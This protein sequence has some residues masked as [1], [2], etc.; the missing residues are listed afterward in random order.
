V[1]DTGIIDFG[2]GQPEDRILPRELLR[3]AAQH[4]L[5]G[6]GNDYLQYGPEQ[7]ARSLRDALAG[8]LSRH[9]GHEVSPDE[10][11]VTNGASH[12]LD[13]VLSRY[14]RPGDVVVV[15]APTY[16]FGL[17]VLH[18]RYV[19]LVSVPVDEEG[20]DTGALRTVI[21]REKPAL[22][23]TIPVFHNPT[24]VSL[25]DA[26]RRQLVELAEAYRIPV[27]ADEVYQLTAEPDRL[28]PPLRRYDPRQV[29]SLGSFSKILGPG[30][31]LGWIECTTGHVAK[32]RDDGV[33][34]SGGGASPM[35][36]AI[37]E[38]AIRRGLQD[39]FLAT[40]RD[41]YDRRRRC[42]CEALR[43][44]LPEGVRVTYP[45][46]GY[47]VW[48]ELP[49][50]TDPR[51]VRVDALAA[52]VG[53]RPGHIFSIDGSFASCL[54]LCFTYYPEEVLVTGIVRLAKVITSH[55]PRCS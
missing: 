6:P 15:E 40:V 24:G 54:R 21:E 31:R 42:A 30:V 52:G 39:Q 32:L 20:L 1:T 44:Y 33:L 37:V 10:L 23:Y 27:V 36:G 26:R 34:R 38:T 2:I 29:L 22:I 49:A 16:F 45:D 28:L 12:G 13:L 43:R 14:T 55:L 4:A 5:A 8:F 51:A 25:S 41:I 9:Y 50:G 7:G 35:T 46:G 17:D 11:L 48:L 18:G 3:E 47:Y 19:R 53:F